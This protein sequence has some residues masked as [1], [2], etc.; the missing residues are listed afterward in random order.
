MSLNVTNYE[1]KPWRVLQHGKSWKWP[2]SACLVCPQETGLDKLF[3]DKKCKYNWVNNIA[4]FQIQGIHQRS[5]LLKQYT[6]LNQ[7][8]NQVQNDTCNSSSQVLTHVHVIM[9]VSVSFKKTCTFLKSIMLGEKTK[10]RLW[11]VILLLAFL[12]T[13]LRSPNNCCRS[14]LFWGGTKR[15]RSCN[16]SISLA[17]DSSLGISKST[18]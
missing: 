2:A 4:Q 17:S 18:N 1:Y 15:N 12:A 5:D 9:I 6:F 11:A 8:E 7:S 16:A 3:S 13:R 10:A 14:I